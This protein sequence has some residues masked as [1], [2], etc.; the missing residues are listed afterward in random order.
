MPDLS[1]DRDS[2]LQQLKQAETAAEQLLC[3]VSPQDA[4]SELVCYFCASSRDRF[5]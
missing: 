3:R 1:A 4:E 5:K 2:I